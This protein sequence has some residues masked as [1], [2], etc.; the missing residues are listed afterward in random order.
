MSRKIRSSLSNI[1]QSTLDIPADQYIAGAGP[2]GLVGNQGTYGFQGY[3]SSIADLTLELYTPTYTLIDNITVHSQNI[4]YTNI[5]NLKM[6]FGT[7]QCSN[8]Q[9]NQILGSHRISLPPIFTTYYSCTLTMG[10]TTEYQS[11]AH[12]IDQTNPNY[13][14]VQYNQG[15]APVS[16]QSFTVNIMIIGF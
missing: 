1:Q 8:T 4:H 9:L 11:T 2:Q 15:I 3:P 16:Y 10:Q 6:L 14:Q 13:I 5:G 12:V 7:I